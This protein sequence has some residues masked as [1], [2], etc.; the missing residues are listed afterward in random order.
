MQKKGKNKISKNDNKVSSMK[1]FKDRL[2]IITTIPGKSMKHIDEIY[3][4]KTTSNRYLDRLIN[5]LKVSIVSTKKFLEDDCL[6][7]ASSIAYTAAVSFIPMITVV[8]WF[9][10]ISSQVSTEK[11][12]NDINK[13]VIEYNLT[14]LNLS[15]IFPVITGLINN[16][17]KIGGIGLA[18]LIVS[19]TSMMRSVENSLNDI[20]K[21]KKNRPMYL[22]IV[23]YW[24]TLTLGPILLIAGTSLL[25]TL[26]QSFTDPTNNTAIMSNKNIWVAGDKARLYTIKSSKDL[27]KPQMLNNDQIDFTNQR[28]YSF[29][30][31]S[32]KFI[33]NNKRIESLTLN[34]FN[35][36]DIQ[37][38]KKRGWIVGSNGII[39]STIDKGKKWKITR[40]DSFHFSKII[41]LDA[42]N[43]YIAAN[44]GNLFSTKNGGETW[45]LRQL[46]PSTT[47]FRDIF[48]Y[49][50]KGFICGTKGILMTTTDRGD[51]WQFNRLAAA[52]KNKNWY[53]NLNRMYKV[54]NTLWMLSDEGIIFKSQNMGNTWKK[55]KFLGYNYY[56]AVFKSN[57][58][59]YI[60]GNKGAII[61]TKDG[62]KNWSVKVVPGIRIKSLLRKDKTLWVFGD[63][64]LMMYSKDGGN[65][66]K[67]RDGTNSILLILNFLAP[68]VL[69]W[70]FFLLVY[71][72]MPNTKIPIKYSS[73]G[74]AFTSAVWVI[75]ILGFIVYVKAF[76]SSTFAIY[77]ALVS[78]PLSLLIVYTT[79]S[80]VLF[81]AEVSYTLMHPESYKDLRKGLKNKENIHVFYGLIILEQ[82]YKKFEEG[83]GESSFNDILKAAFHNVEQVDFF[84]NLFLKHNIILTTAENGYLP[85]QTAMSLR[86][87]EVIE[88]IQDIGL[89]IP[90]VPAKKSQKDK[91]KEIF[92]KIKTSRQKA[93]GDM[94]LKDF[95]R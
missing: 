17:G 43:G 3:K 90:A 94:T 71:T 49:G 31:N 34:K 73:I 76:A 84:T 79:A 44:K 87:I 16:A 70:L 27:K 61:H 47:T 39:L 12:I 20:W 85:A 21:V 35:F 72:L 10:T 95:M 83:K 45:T 6:T 89:E 74:A 64:G 55:I 2:S 15:F 53:I 58:D 33:L 28:S 82:I 41:M 80:I 52:K 57:K 37:F 51:T 60:S 91:V 67:G 36:H 40:W 63:A 26:T 62:G 81:G 11:V 93:I 66:W 24:T 18:V 4:G 1:S 32:Q 54:K 88:I 42:K 7:K 8:L 14:H 59:I 23:Y 9:Y 30:S 48:F 5:L 19:A 25:T 56:S 86:V 38:I 29:D 13:L 69:I 68:F 22:K 65:T 46:A 50:D 78:I 77:G 92:D 75:F